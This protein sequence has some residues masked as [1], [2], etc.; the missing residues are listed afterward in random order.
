MTIA[1]SCEETQ[2]RR[3]GIGTS[4]DEVELI[5][6]GDTKK[7]MSRERRES[8]IQRAQVF[9]KATKVLGPINSVA[10][11]MKTA[12]LA[13][14]I[15]AGCYLLY[16]FKA[17]L[18]P[19]FLAIL[20]MYLVDP[21]VETLDV[22]PKYFCCVCTSHGRRARRTSRGCSRA[23]ASLCAV[24]LVCV[25]FGLIGYVTMLSVNALDVKAYTMG[26]STLITEIEAF[27]KKIGLD[28]SIKSTLKDNVDKLAKMVLTDVLDVISTL[29]V[30]LIY[31]TYFLCTRV[32]PSDVGGVWEKVDRDIQ[33]FVTL[34]AYLSLFVAILVSI[35][36]VTLNVGL[37]MVWGILTF[38]L[39]WIPNMGAMIASV[40]PIGII[41]ITPGEIMN[42]LE[43]FLAIMLPMS[44]HFFVGNFIEPKVFGRRLEMDPVVVVLSLSAWGLIW[45]IVGMMLSVPLTAAFKILLTT[46]NIWP[47][48]VALMEGRY[49]DTTA[50]HSVDCHEDIE[51]SAVLT[52]T[53]IVTDEDLEFGGQLSDEENS[54]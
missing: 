46:L 5:D 38:I 15:A 36:Y 49:F 2:L 6:L 11:E 1:L 53:D 52:H 25:F 3:R 33:R 7:N 10:I 35:V 42:P 41:A 24:A 47:S 22:A 18:I 8:D 39:N 9:D 34:K 4:I 26:Y 27:M 44:F 48:M 17:V 37:A 20:L 29:F 19:F 14:G 13:T 12:I 21:L 32:R 30:T 54:L 31:L 50:V 28:F 16:W 51:Y 45:G 40:L 43:K 23:F